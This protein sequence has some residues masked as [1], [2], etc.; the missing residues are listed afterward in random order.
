MGSI[1]GHPFFEKTIKALPR[2]AM[3]YGMPYI[4]VMASTGPLFL[5]VV[6]KQYKS[7]SLPPDD[8][9]RMLM[10][11]EYAGNDW[12]M[13]VIAKGS[14]WH[15]D[16][17]RTIFWMGKHWLLLTVSGFAIGGLL[18]ASMLVCWQRYVVGRGRWAKKGGKPGSYEMLAQEEGRHMQ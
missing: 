5:S 8:H 11:D 10:P 9:V 18:I 12:S 1:P 13:F 14:S 4:T 16:D 7:D 3:S 6:W 2:Y 15:G 17:A